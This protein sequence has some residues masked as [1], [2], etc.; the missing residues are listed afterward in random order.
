MIGFIKENLRCIILYS[1]RNGIGRCQ[2]GWNIVK[3]WW[4]LQVALSNNE[5]KPINLTKEANTKFGIG[6]ES[7]SERIGRHFVLAEVW[8]STRVKKGTAAATETLL[9]SLC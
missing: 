8:P 3:G 7:K 2:V 9:S 4:Q 5:G 1:Y 6:V